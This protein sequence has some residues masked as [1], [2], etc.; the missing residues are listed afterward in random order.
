MLH[1]ISLLLDG[2]QECLDKGLWGQCFCTALGVVRADWLRWLN[3][4]EAEGCVMAV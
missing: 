4:F 3:T 1:E 2:L